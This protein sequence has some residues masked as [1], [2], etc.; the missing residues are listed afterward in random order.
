M[1]SE[2]Y[3]DNKIA[4][5]IAMSAYPQILRLNADVLIPIMEFTSTD[6]N[7]HGNRKSCCW[8][9]TSLPV[10]SAMIK[11]MIMIKINILHAV[12][13]HRFIYTFLPYCCQK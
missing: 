11:I 9:A 5:E 7:K 2:Q 10:V 6:M 4:D 12:S 8:T 3:N 13:S 1:S